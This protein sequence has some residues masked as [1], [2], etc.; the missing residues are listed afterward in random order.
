MTTQ[1]HS[2]WEAVRL[3][4]ILFGLLKQAH[5]EATQGISCIGLDFVLAQNQGDSF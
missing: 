4:W 2:K 1:F 5:V 3:C